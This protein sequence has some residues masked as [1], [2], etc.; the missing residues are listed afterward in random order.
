[1]YVHTCVPHKHAKRG[2]RGAH[3]IRMIQRSTTNQFTSDGRQHG[4]LT[5]ACGAARRFGKLPNSSEVVI[6]AP[7]TSQSLTP[8]FRLTQTAADRYDLRALHAPKY[9]SSCLLRVL[10]LPLQHTRICTFHTTTDLHL[11]GR[12]NTRADREDR[13]GRGR[14]LTPRKA[15]RQ[16]TNHAVVQSVSLIHIS[17]IILDHLINL[18]TLFDFWSHT[19]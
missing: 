3:A 18:V 15:T 10:L 1:M 7:D 13:I 19:P 5:A 6:V 16:E 11:A 14:G 17:L 12:K 2:G 8:L 9:S 4:P